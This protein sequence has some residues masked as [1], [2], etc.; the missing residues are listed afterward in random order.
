MFL[1]TLFVYAGMFVLLRKLLGVAMSVY[2]V[3]C[4]TLLLS[5]ILLYAALL[6]SEPLALGMGAMG[7]LTLIFFV[8][9]PLTILGAVALLVGSVAGWLSPST[10]AIDAKNQD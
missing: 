9:L 8:G 1:V 3:A 10:K 4:L 7:G 2:G 5:P 6:L